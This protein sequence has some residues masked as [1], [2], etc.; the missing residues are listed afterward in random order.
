LWKV[1]G[2]V[3]HPQAQLQRAKLL[4][5]VSEQRNIALATMI[6]NAAAGSSPEATPAP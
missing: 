2:L 1:S 4:L 5:R 6:R 3:V